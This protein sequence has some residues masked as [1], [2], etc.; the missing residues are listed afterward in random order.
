MIDSAQFV[1]RCNLP[2]LKNSYE[3][4]VGIKT[5]LVTANPSILLEKYGALNGR[6]RPFVESLRSYG[7]SLLLLPAF[8]FSLNTPVCLRAV[9]TIEDFE[10][11]IRPVFFN[12]DYLQNLD[13]FW[14]SQGLRAVR[15]TT[16]IMMT[17]LAL[18]LCDNVHL[19][20]FWPFSNHPHKLYALTNH[21]YD[22]KRA[23]KTEFHAM[24]AEFDLLLRLHS[25]GVLKLHLGD[26]Q[27][28][29]K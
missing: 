11:P 17:S 28:G 16:G 22:D 5:D 24:P 13:L 12:P 7:N 18:E 23:A 27:T 26:C 29:E 2:P 4:H 21:Y 6:R 20:G 19:Y 1:I 10:S 3:K 8:S 15:L 14:R 9:Y 25:Q